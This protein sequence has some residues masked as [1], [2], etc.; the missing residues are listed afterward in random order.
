MVPEVLLVQLKI[1]KVDLAIR[2]LKHAWSNLGGIGERLEAGERD[3]LRGSCSISQEQGDSH[4]P[5]RRQRHE[6]I[7][8]AGQRPVLPD[9]QCPPPYPAEDGQRHQPQAQEEP[10]QRP[11]WRKGP[12]AGHDPDRKKQKDGAPE[13]VTSPP[14]LSRDYPLPTA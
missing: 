5:D 1:F 4:R 8:N 3:V 11:L 10:M 9:P 14:D 6:R 7:P 12:R 2:K 13:Q